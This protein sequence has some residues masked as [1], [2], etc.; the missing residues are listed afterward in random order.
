MKQELIERFSKEKENVFFNTKILK[1]HISEL[2]KEYEKNGFVPRIFTAKN[3]GIYGYPVCE[4]CG[5]RK[6]FSGFNSAM[7]LHLKGGF[8][9]MD[10][11]SKIVSD[12]D[13]EYKDMDNIRGFRFCHLCS[14][15]TPYLVP[16][17]V[18]TKH[19][20]CGICKH[21]FP[22]ITDWEGFLPKM[23]RLIYDK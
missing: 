18:R 15:P 5:R 14:L 16:S 19:F 6:K 12:P 11:Q 2:N 17:G 3:L 23:D 4:V 13:F 22:E 20:V 1:K 10:C 21:D 8:T 7:L 9:C